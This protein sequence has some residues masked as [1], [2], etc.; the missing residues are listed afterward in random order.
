MINTQFMLGVSGS[1]SKD[2]HGAKIMCEKVSCTVVGKSLGGWASILT[3][4]R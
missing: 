2:S 1:L 3:I 4:L